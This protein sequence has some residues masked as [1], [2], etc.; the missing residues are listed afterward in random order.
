MLVSLR[1]IVW[2]SAVLWV[3]HPWEDGGT[4]CA[5]Y[6]RSRFMLHDAVRSKDEAPASFRRILTTIR[7]LGHTV[8]RLRV[9]NDTVFLG[10]AFRNL[11]YE[12]NIAVEIT[13]LCA[14][15]QH[16]RIERPWGTLVPMAQSMIRQ[17]TLPKSYWALA[18]AA[19]VGVRNRVHSGGAGGVPFTFA[20]GRRVD[21]SSMRV[22]GCPAR[23]YVESFNGANLTIAHGRVSLWVTL[24]SYRR[25]WC[26]ILLLIGW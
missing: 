3:F 1:F 26:S 6:F 18:M 7:S 12:F 24:P 23:I 5:V 21:L 17:A 9:D 16:G 20:T 13:A 19:A 14:H 4:A 2:I 10:D 25:G 22:F 15:W 11:L 8:R